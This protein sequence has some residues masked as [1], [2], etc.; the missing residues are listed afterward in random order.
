M[1]ANGLAK[2][3]VEKMGKKVYIFYVDYAMGQSDGRQFKTA[4]EKLGG[5]VVGVAGAPLDTKDFSPWFGDINAKNPYVLFIAFSSPP[6]LPLT[7]HPPS[8]ALTNTSSLPAPN[9]SL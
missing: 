7:P 3:V 5:E 8:L 6:S 1:Q 2:Y 9:S 4:V